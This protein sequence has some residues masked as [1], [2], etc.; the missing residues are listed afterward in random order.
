MKQEIG[1]AS[2][3]SC[4]YQPLWLVFAGEIRVFH[5]ASEILKSQE[6]QNCNAFAKTVHVKY[7]ILENVTRKM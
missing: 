5:S 1:S 6:K 7:L 2:Y 4:K 3:N